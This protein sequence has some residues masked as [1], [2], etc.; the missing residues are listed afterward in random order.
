[1]FWKYTGWPCLAS[2]KNIGDWIHFY[3]TVQAASSEYFQ[4]AALN[5]GHSRQ[6]MSKRVANLLS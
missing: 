6:E 1:M 5:P 2:L 4:K 3:R